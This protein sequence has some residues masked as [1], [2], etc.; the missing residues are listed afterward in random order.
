MSWMRFLLLAEEI[1]GIVS[2]INQQ[3]TNYKQEFFKRILQSEIN[4]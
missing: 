4:N 2:I 1:F 3:T